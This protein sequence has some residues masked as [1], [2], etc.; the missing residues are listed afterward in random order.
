MDAGIGTLVATPH[1]SSRC[2]NDH[3]TIA[4]L[5]GEVNARLR[6]EGVELDVL[7]GAEIAITYLAEIGELDV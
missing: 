6:E 2:P 4:R 5:V 3:D 1:V 7:P